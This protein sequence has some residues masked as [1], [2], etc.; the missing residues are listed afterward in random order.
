MLRGRNTNYLNIDEIVFNGKKVIIFAEDLKGDFDLNKFKRQGKYSQKKKENST[1]KEYWH[2][3]VYHALILPEG[4][5]SHSQEWSHKIEETDRDML[6][7]RC[8]NP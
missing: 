8:A 7:Q 2:K 6:Y 3:I 1:L 5:R 4:G